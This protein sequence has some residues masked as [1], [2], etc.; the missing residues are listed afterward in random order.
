M[1]LLYSYYIAIIHNDYIL[2]HTDMKS[3]S[4]Y[5]LISLRRHQMFLDFYKI[6]CY[7]LRRVCN[8]KTL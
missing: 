5:I 8:N 3:R 6:I 7:Y 1:T 4:A 2:E